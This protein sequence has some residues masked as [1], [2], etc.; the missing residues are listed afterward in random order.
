MNDNM[1]E[2]APSE[3][4][5]SWETAASISIRST[6]NIRYKFFIS[7]NVMCK[8]GSGAADVC[9]SRIGFCFASVILR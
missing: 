2:I 6:Q 4:T 5:F 3:L 8:T 9:V 1:N 7:E